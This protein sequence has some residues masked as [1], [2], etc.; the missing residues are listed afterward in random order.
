MEPQITE[1][2]GPA[3]KPP[4]TSAWFPEALRPGKQALNVYLP[5]WSSLHGNPETCC[6][7]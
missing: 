5:Q 2:P 3:K 7:S 6:V 1:V 4:E